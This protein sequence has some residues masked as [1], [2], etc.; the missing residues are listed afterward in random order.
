MNR[1]ILEYFTAMDTSIK[2]LDQQVNSFVN[3]DYQ[4][5]G[6]PYVIP[7]EKMQFCQAIV[8]FEEDSAGM[9]LS[10]QNPL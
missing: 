7:G 6:S 3:E 9:S 10:A 5:Y 1:R 4:P 8:R 2:G